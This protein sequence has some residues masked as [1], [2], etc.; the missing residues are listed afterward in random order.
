MARC[1]SCGNEYAKAFEVVMQ[2]E[3]HTFDSFECA[4]HLLAPRCE[5]CGIRIMGHGVEQGDHIF[6][7]AQCA[8]AVG[9]NAL[10]DH[11]S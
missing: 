8:R 9:M 3:A 7:C 2:G 11:A 5:N 1:E 10:R 4:V 6:C